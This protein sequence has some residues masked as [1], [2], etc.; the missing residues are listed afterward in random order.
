MTRIPK[1]VYGI[2]VEYTDGKSELHAATTSQREASKLHEAAHEIPG[3]RVV[4]TH[5][6]W[7]GKR[8]KATS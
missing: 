8:A 7:K 6:F 2:F 4:T 5:P 1:F 3:V